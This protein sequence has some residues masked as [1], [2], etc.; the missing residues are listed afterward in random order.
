MSKAT[1]LKELLKDKNGYVGYYYDLV[2]ELIAED[3]KVSI[4]DMIKPDFDPFETVDN[5]AA[6][7]AAFCRV[8]RWYL[9]DKDYKEFMKEFQ[10]DQTHSY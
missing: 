6:D 3:L 8:L 10:S 5:K 4:R 1:L 9:T 2:D 7:L